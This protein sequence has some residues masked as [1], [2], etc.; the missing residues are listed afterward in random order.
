MKRTVEIS[1]DK[2]GMSKWLNFGIGTSVFALRT[3]PKIDE[4]FETMPAWHLRSMPVPDL[5]S[6]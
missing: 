4:E 2:F 3:L 5:L 6:V 1:N